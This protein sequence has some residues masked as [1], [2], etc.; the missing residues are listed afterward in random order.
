MLPMESTAMLPRFVAAPIP[1]T[2][3]EPALLE[4]FLGGEKV[5][6]PSEER[7][8]KISELP[9]VMMLVKLSQTTSM[10][11]LESTTICAPPETPAMLDRFLGAE[12]VA[13]P[14]E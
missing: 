11:P 14:S 1:G 12:K 6:P 5:A 7:L 10:L 13:P 9:P 2:N 4:R 8:K 3:E